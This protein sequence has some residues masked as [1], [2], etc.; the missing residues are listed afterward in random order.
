MKAEKDNSVNI[1]TLVGYIIMILAII[2]I[3]KKIYHRF[4]D[5]NGEKEPFWENTEFMK[6]CKVPYYSSNECY[7][8]NVRLIDEKNAQIYF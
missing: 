5:N 3:G 2:W 4:F 8:L 6:V 1:L 7:K